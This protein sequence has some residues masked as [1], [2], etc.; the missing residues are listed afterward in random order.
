MKALGMERIMNHRLHIACALA[1]SRPIRCIAA[2]AGLLLAGGCKE[3]IFIMPSCP[4]TIEVGESGTLLANVQNP[5]AIARYLWEVFPEDAASLQN[6]TAE[7]TAFTA[8][9]AG[10]VTFRLTAADGL[11]QAISQCQSEIVAAGTGG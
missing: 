1:I 9:E 6:A 5:G 7:N 3:P 11:Y 4:A 8:E 2:V 10:T